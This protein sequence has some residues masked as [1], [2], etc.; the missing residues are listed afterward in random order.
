MQL[1]AARLPA[2]LFLILIQQVW[3]PSARGFSESISLNAGPSQISAGTGDVSGPGRGHEDWSSLA[4]GPN[5]L[6]PEK[7]LLG[8]KVE[9]PEFTRELIEVQWR[10][11]D[12]I[13]LFVVRPHGIEKPPVILYL[14]SYPYD[15]P[16]FLD[17]GFCE[18]VTAEGFGAIGFVS[19]LTGQRYHGRP[20]RKWFVSELQEALVL[21]VHDVQ[22]ILNFLSDRGDFDMKRVGMFGEGSGATIAILA[23]AVDARIKTL[24]LVNPW[25]AWPDWMAKSTLVPEVERPNYVKPDF[26]HRVEPFDPIQWLPKLAS[27]RVRLQDIMDDTITPV[28]CKKQIESVAPHNALI[29][30]Y[31]DSEA[32]RKSLAGGQLFKWIK[33][34]VGVTSLQTAKV[35]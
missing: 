32:A 6:S 35:P 11:K 26:L 15:T 27:K 3:Y 4:I 12:P 33:Q 20:M 22:M 2:F 31:D 10:E 34:Q 8:E 1:R 19:A 24:D 7:P 28:E 14:Y 29:V 16:R 17:K 5:E 13:H 25:G 21:S 23:A 18:R 30:R 9:Y